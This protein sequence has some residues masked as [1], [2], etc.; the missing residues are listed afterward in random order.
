ML[1]EEAAL[2][3]TIAQNE[4]PVDIPVL[5]RLLPWRSLS[6][7]KVRLKA[8][9]R[10]RSLMEEVARAIELDINEED[11]AGQARD[12][13]TAGEPAAPSEQTMVADA[14]SLQGAVGVV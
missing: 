4:S 10:V 2:A 8:D 13:E 11:F 6:E 7:L 9:G 1:G 12:D 3:K 14:W 5:A